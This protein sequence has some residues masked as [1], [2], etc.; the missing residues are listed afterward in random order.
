MSSSTDES[1]YLK[2]SYEDLIEEASKEQQSQH[3]PPVSSQT[4]DHSKSN[5]FAS[6]ISGQ[7]F[8]R[9][10]SDVSKSEASMS[11]ISCNA[12]YDKTHSRCC[13]DCG[14][15]YCRTCKKLKMIKLAKKTWSCSQHKIREKG[16]TK[17]ISVEEQRRLA[18]M[19]ESV[20]EMLE[21]GKGYMVIK[22]KLL[23]DFKDDGMFFERHKKKIRAA[24]FEFELNRKIHEMVQSGHHSR[25]K[26]QNTLAH[27][28]GE[29][30]ANASMTYVD[31]VTMKND[32]KKT[33]V[34]HLEKGDLTKDAIRERTISQFANETKYNA[35]LVDQV[36]EMVSEWRGE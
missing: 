12:N 28:F 32:I 25:D 2:E 27:V 21:Q 20:Q 16:G 10:S 31:F 9:T 8:N 5:I 15:W 22:R 18:K 23:R 34:E 24:C 33:I 13:V 19:H 4:K 30:V 6:F 29:E 7:F 11:C 3:V 14:K 35:D 1:G 26:I 36:E 17:A